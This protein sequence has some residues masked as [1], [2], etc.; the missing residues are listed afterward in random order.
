VR[1]WRPNTALA[2]SAAVLYLTSTEPNSRIREAEETE[3]G[4]EEGEEEGGKEGGKEGGAQPLVLT[5]R[6]TTRPYACTP[7]IAR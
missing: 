3:E 7:S 4:M 1:A 2:A 5:R 6:A